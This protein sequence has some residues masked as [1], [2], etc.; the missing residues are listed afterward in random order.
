MM[1]KNIAH[2]AGVNEEPIYLLKTYGAYTQDQRTVFEIT[3]DQCSLVV[4]PTP[5]DMNNKKSIV[6]GDLSALT[7]LQTERFQYYLDPATDA[8]VFLSHTL[9]TPLTAEELEY[10]NGDEF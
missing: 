1:A 10:F 4:I 8:V 3:M 2:P 6:S 5:D 7:T 9:I